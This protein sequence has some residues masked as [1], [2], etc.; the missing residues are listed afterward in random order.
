MPISVTYGRHH[1]NTQILLGKIRF[2]SSRVRYRCQHCWRL[3]LF[4]APFLVQHTGTGSGQRTTVLQRGAKCS[5]LHH[6][7]P[8]ITSLGEALAQPAKCTSLVGLTYGEVRLIG[9]RAGQSLRVNPS[10]KVHTFIYKVSL[11][12]CLPEQSLVKRSFHLL[13]NNN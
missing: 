8:E 11:T 1:N 5:V 6:P 10:F 9:N 2:Q 3:W 13:S 12:F 7:T 4:L